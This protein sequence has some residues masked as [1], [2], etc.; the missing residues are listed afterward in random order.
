MK[1]KKTTKTHKENKTSTLAQ[2]FT[3][4]TEK[5]VEL[6]QRQAYINHVLCTTYTRTHNTNTLTVFLIRM[7]YI[8]LCC[9]CAFV[10]T[11]SLLI[12]SFVLCLSSLSLSLW[13][14]RTYLQTRIHVTINVFEAPS[15][16]THNKHISIKYYKQKTDRRANVNR[17]FG[18][19]VYAKESQKSHLQAFC[20]VLFSFI[21]FFFEREKKIDGVC[22]FIFKV[23]HWVVSKRYT[24]VRPNL[25]GG[26]R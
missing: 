3:S 13:H 1:K 11:P 7:W 5:L 6:Y 14:T 20:F 16:P 10:C 24:C 9:S 8:Y 22:C 21:F 12:F 23:V 15:I 17:W 18:R 4:L 19:F 2:S 25:C 26:V